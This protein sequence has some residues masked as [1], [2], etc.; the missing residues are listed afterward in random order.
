MSFT[1]VL[2]A[3]V[4]LPSLFTLP[5]IGRPGKGMYLSGPK[6]QTVAA[7]SEAVLTCG[8]GVSLDSDVKQGQV[9]P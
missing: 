4:L 3:T 2:L 7:G 6:N 8:D 1:T 9:K 5:A